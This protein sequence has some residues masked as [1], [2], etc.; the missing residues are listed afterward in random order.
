MTWFCFIPLVENF[1]FVAEPTATSF[2]RIAKRFH[3][4][5]IIT[6]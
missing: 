4:I 6:K 2:V 3:K 5:I 1:S